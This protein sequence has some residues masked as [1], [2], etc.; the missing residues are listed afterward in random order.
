MR[1]LNH[2]EKL[3][4]Y[5]PVS[6]LSGSSLS[7]AFFTVLFFVVF[8]YF[9]MVAPFHFIFYKL[10]PAWSKARQ[11]YPELPGSKEQW[12]EIKWSLYTSLIFAVAGV[13]MGLLW[14]LGF[15][16]IY[17]LFDQYGLWYLPVSWF[18]MLLLHETY[19]YWT[20]RWLHRPGIFEKFHSIHHASL[21]PSPWASFSFHP[22]ESVI[23]AAFVPLVILV[24]PL[25]PVLILWHLTFMTISAIT[26][27][28]GFEVLPRNA[29]KNKW[30][31]LIVSG[32]HHTTHHRYFRNNYGL[33]FT[34]WDRWM[35]TEKTSYEKDFDRVFLNESKI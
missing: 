14:E 19:F 29:L 25:H 16:R 27:H 34:F 33:F 23:N 17:L 7:L 26:N 5:L 24:L 31:F 32:V 3:E 10:K 22:I 13:V 35:K 9:L 1:E 12:F 20:H 8:R 21:R 4:S 28:S 6:L 15:T 18:L 11:I 2:F 30:G